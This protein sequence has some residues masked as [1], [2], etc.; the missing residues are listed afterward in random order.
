MKLTRPIFVLLICLMNIVY[1]PTCL[2]YEES[3][4]DQVI[5][6]KSMVMLMKEPGSKSPVLMKLS[7][8][9]FIVLLDRD[10]INVN[11]VAVYTKANASFDTLQKEE[12]RFG[13][14]KINDGNWY[15]VIH[16]KTGEEGWVRE[17]DVKIKYAVER[18]QIKLFETEK[19]PLLINPEI[20]II[21]NANK[22]LKLK[23]GEKIYVIN[24]QSQKTVNIES[25][26]YKY[27]ASAPEVIPCF[28]EQTFEG[29]NR[30]WWKFWIASRSDSSKHNL[31][32]GPIKKNKFRRK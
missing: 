32:K 19:D 23:V 18:K 25:G 29:G 24:K 28:G 3:Y 9:D 7:K 17:N 4:V 15:N 12:V 11:Y 6:S 1:I 14:T 2:P 31:D 20:L 5:L 10:P 13:N 26:T 22:D 30:Y 16:V 8:K 21:N 27:H